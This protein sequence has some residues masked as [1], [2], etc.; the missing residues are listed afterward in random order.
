MRKVQTNELSSLVKEKP[1][2]GFVICRV[3]TE[4]NEVIPAAFLNPIGL[5]I[6]M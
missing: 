3:R 4:A 6:E 2:K 1:N 5:S